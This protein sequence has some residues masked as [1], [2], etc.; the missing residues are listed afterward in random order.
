MEAIKVWFPM[1]NVNDLL[2]NICMA[3]YGSIPVLPTVPAGLTPYC[4]AEYDTDAQLKFCTF[5]VDESLT[6]P[7]GTGL[8]ARF[9]DAVTGLPYL[10]NAKPFSAVQIG[11]KIEWK[12]Q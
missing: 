5:K 1:N 9:I 2:T 3:T 6:A 10:V 11:D 7:I 8:Q 12:P 4:W